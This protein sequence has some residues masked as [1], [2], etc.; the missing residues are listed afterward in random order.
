MHCTTSITA[1]GLAPFDCL[2]GCQT[3]YYEVV[4]LTSFHICMSVGLSDWLP[5]SCH[6]DFPTPEQT[7]AAW[8]IWHMIAQWQPL[9]QFCVTAHE[10]GS[11]NRP[12]G[13]YNTQYS[14][15][16]EF[17]TSLKRGNAP[18]RQQAVISIDR[19]RIYGWINRPNAIRFP[20]ISRD[21]E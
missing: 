15:I 10:N 19:R 9:H 18:N 8:F 3:D 1:K 6:A 11:A 12:V 21:I 7:N 13:R 4:R 2:N 5:W 17:T 16:T 14:N 20:R